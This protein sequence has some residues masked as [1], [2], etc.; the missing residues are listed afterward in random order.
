MG[1]LLSCW[2]KFSLC[3]KAND[4]DEN[5]FMSVETAVLIAANDEV[6]M[7]LGRKVIV[8]YV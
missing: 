2:S 5:S 3:S 7:I 8:I 6:T 4:E 1:L